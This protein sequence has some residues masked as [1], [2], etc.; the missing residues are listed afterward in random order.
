MR[1][2]HWLAWAAAG[3]LIAA[4][5]MKLLGGGGEAEAGRQSR[6]KVEADS[7][8]AAAA[9]RPGG[10]S[11]ERDGE[12][13]I[14]VA[15][16]VR[17]PGL[18]R[19]RAGSRVAAAIEVA[20]GTLR[21]ADVTGVNLAAPLEDG[22]QV[23]VPTLGPGGARAAAGSPATAGAPGS[24]GAGA[25]AGTPLS[26]SSATLEQLDALDGIGP[27]L[28]AR[29]LEYRDSQGGFRSV[30]QLREVAGI[31]DKR[32]EALRKAVRP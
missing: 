8:A 4:I 27:T 17:R 25:A 32:F 29:I 12:L 16:A 26:L 23:I 30:D 11:I 18:H 20:G 15:G 21:R 2:A 19:L 10:V 5:A 1:K 24:Q 22:Q 3:A 9:T 14:H 6:V 13:Y 31:G 28:A 7:T